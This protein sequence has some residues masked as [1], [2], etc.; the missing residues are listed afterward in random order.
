MRYDYGGVNDCE[1]K[2]EIFE[3]DYTTKILGTIWI[4]S[5]GKRRIIEEETEK[6]IYQS[7]YFFVTVEDYQIVSI[8]FFKT[9]EYEPVIGSAGKE[10]YIFNVYTKPQYRNRGLSKKSMVEGIEYFKAQ[11]YD[12]FRLHTNQPIARHMYHQLGF[13]DST[14]SMSLF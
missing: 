14:T 10:I 1:I 9:I 11:G 7:L 6:Y 13:Y 5:K 4:S 3:R 2:L 12:C 8:I